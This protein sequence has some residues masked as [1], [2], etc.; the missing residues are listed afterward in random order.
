MI[1]FTTRSLEL[2]WYCA[3]KTEVVTVN[4]TYFGRTNQMVVVQRLQQ[5]INVYTMNHRSLTLWWPVLIFCTDSTVHDK[6][7]LYKLQN[8]QTGEK[9][10]DFLEFRSKIVDV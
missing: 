1:I 9:R 2:L 6:F 8:T 3:K 5:N 10:L 4:S 7:Y